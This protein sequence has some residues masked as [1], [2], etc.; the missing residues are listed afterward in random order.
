VLSCEYDRRE[1]ANAGEWCNEPG[2]RAR[3]TAVRRDATRVQLGIGERRRG[4]GRCGSRTDAVQRRRARE[5][6][7]MCGV[8]SMAAL[9]SV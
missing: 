6:A 8:L 4:V 1:V 9:S 7:M 2:C 3:C 5:G